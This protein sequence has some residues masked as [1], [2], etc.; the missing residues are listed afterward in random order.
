MYRQIT[1]AGL[2]SPSKVTPAMRDTAYRDVRD[3]WRSYLKRDNN[4]RGVVVIG[5]SQGTRVL[6]QLVAEEIDAKPKVRRRLISAILLGGIVLVKEGEDAGGETSATT[7]TFEL[8]SCASVHG[9]RP[10]SRAGLTAVP[11]GR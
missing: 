4:G 9:V 3:A 7:P 6:R 2:G 1:L 5:H 11:C 8:A 10:A